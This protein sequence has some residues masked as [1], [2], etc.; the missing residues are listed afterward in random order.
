[1]R[2]ISLPL[3]LYAPADKPGDTAGSDSGDQGQ[4]TQG[5][6]NQSTGGVPTG[7]EAGPGDGGDAHGA[8]TDDGASAAGDAVAAGDDA[9]KPVKPTKDWRDKEIAKKHAQL[10]A[11][12]TEAAKLR[13]ENKRLRELAD[14]AARRTDAGAGVGTGDAGDAGGTQPRR[15]EFRTQQE[16]DAAVERAASEKAAQTQ[17]S[18]DVTAIE[19]RGA[20]DYGDRW[21]PTLE[22]LRTL[23]GFDP[24][25]F[26]SI[27]ATDDPVR[28]LYELGSNP[29]NY[30]RIMELPAAKR[31][32]ELV[33]LS[34]TTSNKRTISGA[35]KPVD[36]I[37]ARGSTDTAALS[38]DLPEDEWRR[39][40]AA[41]KQAAVGRPWS[42]RQRA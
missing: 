39:R 2:L 36:A 33:K 5:D 28:V 35:P 38:D 41:Q 16:F 32:I 27:M 14:A 17:L 1:M 21:A 4:N 42:Q 8:A 9:G 40:R 29:E 34:L 20:K 11:E 23:G 6:Q 12:K 30:Q 18:R 31:Q 3:P 10:Q 13:E 7:Q 37:G 25:T 26:G 24:D 19:E 15:Q 22:T